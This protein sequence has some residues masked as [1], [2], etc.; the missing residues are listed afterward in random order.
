M[1]ATMMIAV[2]FRLMDMSRNRTTCVQFQGT[3]SQD[4]TQEREL[5][6]SPACFSNVT[7]RLEASLVPFGG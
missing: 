7:P 5:M 1:L 4:S 2:S 3:R 6:F